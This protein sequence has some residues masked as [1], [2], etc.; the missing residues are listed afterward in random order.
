MNRILTAARVHTI[1]PAL[2]LMLPWAIMASSLV[3]NILI[4]GVTDVAEQPGSGTGGLASLY[5]TIAVVHI[6]AVSYLLPFAMSL[7]LTRRTFYL[8]TALFA[9]A[10]ALAY[11]VV[12]YV[13]ALL[14]GAT[15]GWGFGLPFFKGFWW[16][17]NP[18]Q[19]VLVFAVPLCVLS[20]LG[21]WI[22]VVYKRF[23]SVGLY[24]LTTGTALTLGGLFT[25]ITW[26]RA[27]DSVGSWF[28]DQALIGL[29]AG[30]PMLLG[31]LFAMAGYI[32]IRRV[33]P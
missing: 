5:I 2:S 27:W 23:G 29:F 10:Q 28:S 13:L 16:V 17:G 26:Q 20:L 3:I 14:E 30:W 18:V 11:G 1:A 15:N 19:Q 31:A 22:G 32:G 33:V 4:W 8:G 9:A 7:S 25:L 21:M 24:A 6:Q 12:L